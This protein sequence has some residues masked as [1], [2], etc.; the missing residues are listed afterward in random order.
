VEAGQFAMLAVLLGSS[1]LNAAY[2]LPIVYRAFFC[3][4]EQ[5]LFDGPMA[6]APRWC[7]VPPLLTAGLSMVLFF[8]P[9]PFLRLALL[10][11]QTITGG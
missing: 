1:L 5:S 3:S 10:A 4:P 8:Y 9:Q 2:F 7:L 11:V 6:E